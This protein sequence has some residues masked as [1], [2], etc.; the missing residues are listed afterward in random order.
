MWNPSLTAEQLEAHRERWFHRSFGSAWQEMK[1][2]YD[3][4]LV[5]N[6]PA[7]GPNTWAHA[8]RLIE[9][10]DTRLDA[11]VEPA[12]KRRLDDVK[13]FWYYYYLCDTGH[14]RTGSPPTYTIKSDDPL[15]KE[16]VW[17]GQLTS[18]TRR[19]KPGIN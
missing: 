8:I 15:A 12:A 1:A 11:A 18:G 17:K 14:I 13:Q 7:N 3:F 5:D 10:A 2:Y 19:R 16:F 4:M 6:F 9:A